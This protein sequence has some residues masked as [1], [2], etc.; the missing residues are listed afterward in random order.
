MCVAAT[1]GGQHIDFAFAPKLRKLR[2]QCVIRKPAH[3]AKSHAQKRF[4]QRP[5][6]AQQLVKIKIV[7][8]TRAAPIDERRLW[9][10]RRFVN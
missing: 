10:E 6:R 7:V 3:A 9:R 5:R 8:G 4:A 2:A 1:G